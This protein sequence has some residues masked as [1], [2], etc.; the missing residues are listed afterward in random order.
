MTALSVSGLSVRLDGSTLVSDVDFIVEPG[1]FVGV[2]GP[3]GAGKT[4]LLAA[5][6][7]AVESTGDVTIDGKD[8]RTMG[9]RHRAAA[10][11]LVPQR[12]VIPPGV[13]VFEYVLLGR[14]PHLGLLAAESAADLEITARSLETLG[15]GEFAERMLDTLS[16]GEAQRVVV[17]RAIAQGS[18]LLLLDEPTSALDLGHAQRVLSLVDDLRRTNGVTVV[19]AV[20]DLTL[21]A[22]FCDRLVMMSEGRVVASGPAEEVLTT[23]TVR[24][25]YDAPL[26]VVKVGDDLVV[27]PERST[28]G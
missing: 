1:S 24:R 21:A 9:R 8:A 7:G 26:A 14:T 19:A 13:T 4:T 16:G 10:V 22:R 23:E 15:V 3:N 6:A 2:V 18:P 5:I 25:H 20:H 28:H 27:V 11:A 12:P 17:A